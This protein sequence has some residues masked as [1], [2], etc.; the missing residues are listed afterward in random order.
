MP[1]HLLPPTKPFDIT[2]DFADAQSTDEVLEDIYGWMREA[3]PVILEGGGGGDG[4]EVFVQPSAPP[5]PASG[6]VWLDSDDCPVEDRSLAIVQD[7]A[8]TSPATG[9]L[10]LDSDDCY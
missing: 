1:N 6:A 3:T 2:G 7:D 10:W 8:P 9:L 5:D 4:A